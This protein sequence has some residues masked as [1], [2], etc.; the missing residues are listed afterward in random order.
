MTGRDLT[1]EELDEL[2][3]LAADELAE[4]EGAPDDDGCGICYWFQRAPALIRMAR[5]TA[6]ERRRVISAASSALSY[7][8]GVDD[9]GELWDR[10]MI[11]DAI[12]EKLAEWDT[13]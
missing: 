5:R 3:R 2:E 13:E 10:S 11:E 7:H 1:P 9:A 6:E 12:L 8:L 4:H